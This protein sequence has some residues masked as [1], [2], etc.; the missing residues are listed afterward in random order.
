MCIRDRFPSLWITREFAGPFL[1]LAV[2][3]SSSRIIGFQVESDLA[4]T[5]SEGY[6]G[7]VPIRVF[8]D[9]SAAVLGF[10]I[11]PCDE[12]PGYLELTVK[13]LTPRLVG[14]SPAR[15]DTVD[16]VTTATLS[17]SAVIAAVTGAA[18]RV[19][20]EVVSRANEQ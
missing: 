18:R 12:T 2:Y 7:P 6:A 11:L 20:N 4:Q 10:D 5:T 1:H 13:A 3:D 17:S 19:A 14:Y 15:T 8:L 16:A 9:A